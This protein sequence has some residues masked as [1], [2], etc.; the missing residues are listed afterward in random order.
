MALQNPERSWERA[1]LWLLGFFFHWVHSKRLCL[2]DGVLRLGANRFLDY[3]GVYF[4]VYLLV[5][6]Y[7]S[8]TVC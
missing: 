3:L 7:L 4:L 2:N 6:V 5:S 1:V 8:Y